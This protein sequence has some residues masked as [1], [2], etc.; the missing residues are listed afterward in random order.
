MTSTLAGIREELGLGAITGGALA[1]VMKAAQTE[2]ERILDAGRGGH[3]RAGHRVCPRAHPG[4]VQRWLG[5]GLRF[6][7]WT[8]D[9]EADVERCREL[10]IHEITTNWPAQVLSQLRQ[11]ALA[12]SSATT[13]SQPPL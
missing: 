7:V 4:T 3:G 9:A 12:A 2:G 6:R 5:A 13:Q 11:P 8:V 1:N 10:G